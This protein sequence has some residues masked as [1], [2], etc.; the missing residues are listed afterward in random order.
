MIDSGVVDF[1]TA[2]DFYAKGLYPV[3]PGRARIR[4]SSARAGIGPLDSVTV[5]VIDA[6]PIVPLNFGQSMSGT[7]V[8]SA[9]DT[10]YALDLKANDSIDVRVT[11]PVVIREVSG[12]GMKVVTTLGST[13]DGA[14]IFAHVVAPVSGRYLLDA[15][16]G[17]ACHN[18]NCFQT[19]GPFTMTARRSGP[20]YLAAG[21]GRVT[22]T[23]GTIGK[24]TFWVHNL[25]TGTLALRTSVDSS[26]L[27][28]PA[29]LAAPGPVA[30]PA[31]TPSQGAVPLVVSVDA[32]ALPTGP[33]RATLHIAL[34][35]TV[36]TLGALAF[37]EV[38]DINVIDAALVL[39]PSRFFNSLAGGMDGAL[40]GVDGTYL[41]SIN[42]SNGVAT[43]VGP[44]HDYV[45]MA[46]ATKGAMYVSWD[47]GRSVARVMPDYSLVSVSSGVVFAA[48][49]D[50]T[51]YTFDGTSLVR[52]AMT[53]QRTTLL[54]SP[55]PDDRRLA[56]S[57]RDSVLYYSRSG[58]LRRFVL[59]TSTEQALGT[60]EGQFS[61][62][63]VDAQGRIYGF[64][65]GKPN[66]VVVDSL[67]K[68]IRRIVTPAFTTTVAV[69]GNQLF[70]GGPP[71]NSA[72]WRL[73]IP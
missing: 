55:L 26:F 43:I 59:A 72:F 11:G 48:A 49:P 29:S 46:G 41:Y 65:A 31:L 23:R 21:P 52:I 1:S 42:P 69:A 25:G 73:D 62:G 10:R 4:L 8:A 34:D 70:G 12:L 15:W 7:I 45:I 47:F 32:T 64:E 16:R 18:G 35:S 24:G 19:S 60:V 13:Y 63:A 54:F 37:D 33:R 57:A 58:I 39:L 40:W 53:G 6:R 3:T 51:L 30:P 5:R 67:G 2:F 36:W 9:S 28:V 44:P 38:I 20:V 68:V 50:G 22:V 66:V 17:P 61:P 56:Y 27:S 14:T 71:G